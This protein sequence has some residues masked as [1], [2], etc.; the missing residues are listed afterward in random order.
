MAEIRPEELRNEFDAGTLGFETTADLSPDGRIAGQD[1]ALKALAFGLRVQSDG[2]N[3]YVS[4]WSGTGR[5]TTVS[6][7]VE[8][9][10]RK[11]A[12]PDDICYLHNFQRPDEPKYVKLP[13]GKG[14]TFRNDMQE[15][16]DDLEEELRKAFVSDEYQRQRQEVSGRLDTERE[17]LS[18]RLREMG[19]E[20]GFTVNQSPTGIIIMPLRD[21]R[22]LQEAEYEQL[23]K[24]DK[25]RIQEGQHYLQ[26]KIQEGGVRLENVRRDIKAEAQELDRQVALHAV[27]HMIDV[28][29]QR[30]AAFEPVIK[31]L[32]EVL[33]D[34]LKN[35]D[36]LRR[37]EEQQGLPFMQKGPSKES[38]L[39]RYSVNLL[40]DNC[41]MKGAPVIYE[42]NPTYYNVNGQVEYRALFGVLSTDF[43]MIRPGAA[44]RANGGYLIV[45][46]HQ[47]LRDFYAWDGLKKILRYKEIRIEN[48]AER[49]GFAPTSGLKPQAVPVDLKVLLIGTPMLYS[50]LQHYD[51]EFGKLF[52]IKVDF[53]TSMPRDDG[54]VERYAHFAASASR[55]HKLLPFDKSAVG[56]MVN[57]GSRLVEHQHKLTTRFTVIS[58]LMR[59]SDYWARQADGQVVTAEHVRRAWHERIYRSNMYEEKIDELI[60]E[61]TLIVQ[62]EGEAVGQ[63]NGISILQLGDYAFGRPSRITGKSWIGKGGIVDIE[64]ETEL[65]GKIH[66]K[67]VLI[68]NG[69]I[70][71][72]Y[73]QRRPLALAASLCFEQLYEEVDGDSASSAEFYALASSIANVPLRQSLAV[74]GSVDQRGHIQ[75]VG[76]INEKIEGFYRVCKRRGLDGSHGVLVPAANVKH[77]MLDEE[78]VEA[79]RKDE[80]HVYAVETVDQGIALLT[81]MEAGE[82]R[83]DGTYPEGTFN[84]KVEEQLMA[85]SESAAAFAAEHRELVHVAP[86][87]G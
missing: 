19:T 17:R 28:L 75:P 6:K 84:A 33:D 48:I 55:Q 26:Q 74:T 45:Q 41:E 42:H 76:G 59:E 64:R 8:L 46:A 3:I 51:I 53:D 86:E 9:R 31:H 65:S 56:Q 21:G 79:V 52:R 1:R 12:V 23:P 43:T 70:G 57:Y 81:G 77:L 44:H 30:Y 82:R 5:S 67:G 20:R 18:T 24:E 11:E 78:V 7:E 85:F 83:H 40:V 29:K 39:R 80:F 47:I 38:I 49:Y 25:E 14:C 32:D 10:A 63:L 72:R 60:S 15:L 69:L 4:G 61:G 50:L 36:A 87:H 73:A 54:G 68:L 22:P 16:V 71:E 62:T 27:G 13:A 35:I 37:E 2:H 34:I 58:S 66:S